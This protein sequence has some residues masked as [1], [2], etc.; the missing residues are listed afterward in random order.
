MR[1]RLRFV[2]ISLDRNADSQSNRGTMVKTYRNNFS[3]WW[4]PS[5]KNPTGER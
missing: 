3:Y 1:N 2:L 4:W 5:D